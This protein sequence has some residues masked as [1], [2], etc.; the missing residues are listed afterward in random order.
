MATIQDLL[1]RGVEKIYPSREELERALKKKLRVYQGFDP[2]S[3]QLHI[4]HMVGLRKLKQWQNLGHE[5]IFLI[6]DYTATIGDPTGKDTTRVPI[7]HDQVLKNANT[8]KE[9]ASRILKF[10]GEN[11]VKMM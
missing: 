11:P 9:Q 2:T 4:G 6:G 5:V 1:T 7:T 3:P 8:Y 10:D